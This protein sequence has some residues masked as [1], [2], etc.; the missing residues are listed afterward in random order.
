[1]AT[2]RERKRKNSKVTY[3]FIAKLN[4][5]NDNGDYVTKS[6]TYE[7]PDGVKKNLVEQTVKSAAY[8]WE[9]KTKDLYVGY[10][11][12]KGLSPNSTFEECAVKWLENLELKGRSLNHQYTS[13]ERIYKNC[14]QL[15][16]MRLD[17]ISRN[18]IQE[19][20]DSIDR[21]TRTVEKVRTIPSAFRKAMNDKGETFTTLR[22]VIPEPTLLTMIRGDNGIAMKSAERAANALCVAV[23]DICTVERRQE[24][25]AYKTNHLIKE[26]VRE[27]LAFATRKGLLE[28][29]Y[30]SAEFIEYPNVEKKDPRCM[31]QEQMIKACEA[32][33]ADENIQQGTFVLW[34][35]LTG[36]RR[37]E[38]RGVKWHAVDWKHNTIN[39]TDNRVDAYTNGKRITEDKEPKTK[40][41][42][43]IIEIP[44][45]LV[46]QLRK[47]KAWYDEQRINMGDRW[48]DYN[49][50]IFVNKETGKPIAARTMADWA[51]NVTMKVGLG[52]WNLHAYRHTNVSVK[53]LLKVPETEISAQAGH[54]TLSVTR[55]IYAHDINQM[56]R[57]A[58]KKFD[59]M[60]N[61]KAADTNTTIIKFKG[62]N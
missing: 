58:P 60:L 2:I 30:A 42:K 18:V 10:D 37:G 8:E 9:K 54:S 23:H 27:V 7:L 33:I 16:N 48:E 62:E 4:V 39:V 17:K 24:K 15:L 14:K 22:N 40:R 25:Y 19:F 47:Y 1:M 28:R 35:L 13:K 26:T 55:D 32:A 50:Y 45:T 51:D 12:S 46:E 34:L 41:S 11:M 3:Q 6:T 61:A 43:R 20:F 56:S 36:M 29:N 49:E 59:D 31:T 21:R 57:V 53:F 5:K 52:H 38:V 44:D